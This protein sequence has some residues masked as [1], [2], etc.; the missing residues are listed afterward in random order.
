MN[1]QL[2]KQAM[3]LFGF[4]ELD[5][6]I[7]PF[8]NGLINET[9]LI[10]ANSK[11][12]ILQRINHYIFKKPEN[13][14]FNI[15]MLADYFRKNFPTYLFVSTCTAIDGTDLVKTK[16]GYFACFILLRTLIPLM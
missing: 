3:H 2:M 11:K 8:G 10:K 12:Y 16:T 9:W 6:V 13:I 7:L 4:D 5:C 1:L 15:R 14:A